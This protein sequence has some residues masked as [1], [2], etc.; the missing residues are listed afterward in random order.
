MGGQIRRQVITVRG[1]R[2]M[3]TSATNQVG[4]EGIIFRF[5][6]WHSIALRRLSA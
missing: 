3:E 4:N 6:A 1:S 2:K 5:V